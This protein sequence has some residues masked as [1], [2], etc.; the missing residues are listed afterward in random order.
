MP[1]SL[2]AS[3]VA[4]SSALHLAQP[5][6]STLTA[7]PLTFAF[8]ASAMVSALQFPPQ[9]QP[10][11]FAFSASSAAFFAAMSEG[12]HIPPQSHCTNASSVF[13]FLPK[14]NSPI[15]HILL[16]LFVKPIETGM[17]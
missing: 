5:E 1:S 4:A 7:E 2:R 14:P 12:L 10:D 9:Q 17:R 6:P 11:D 3:A 13:F 8:S 15:I 16:K